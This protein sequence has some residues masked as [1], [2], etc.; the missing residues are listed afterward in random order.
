M[1][2]FIL[3]AV[4][5]NPSFSFPSGQVHKKR[6]GMH[7][8]QVLPEMHSC[9]TDDR[10]PDYSKLHQLQAKQSAQIDKLTC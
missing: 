6:D 9:F 2:S 1:R 8:K 5:E 3:A 4:P 7:L 10:V